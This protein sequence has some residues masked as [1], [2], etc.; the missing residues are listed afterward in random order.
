MIDED[1][2]WLK[3]LS[4]GKETA[5]KR[6]YDLY[7]PLFCRFAM[8]YIQDEE[9]AKDIV[10]DVIFDIWHHRKAM[11]DIRS[12]RSYMYK[13]IANKCIDTLRK[14]KVKGTYLNSISEGSDFFL[15]KVLEE[16][17]FLTLRE[18]IKRLPSPTNTIFELSLEG[19]SNLEIAQLLELS[20]DSVKSHKK[21]GKKILYH[22]LHLLLLLLLQKN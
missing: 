7:Y 9:E 17:V 13:S 6:L 3:D 11:D 18:A 19:H 1:I 16:E 22:K 21:R 4:Q 20:L 12:L 8:Q 2:S 10:Q 15:L 14:A 5:F